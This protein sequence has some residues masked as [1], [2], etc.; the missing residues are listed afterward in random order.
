MQL[1]DIPID[2]LV[3][4]PYN[5]RI[6]LKPGMAE[7]ER[8]KRS[9]TEFELVQPIVWNRRTGY[10]VGGHQRLSILKARGDAIA[11]C[12][13][14]DLDPARE[15]ALNVTLNNERVGGDWEPD[16]LIDVLAD[17]EELPD[18]DATLTGFSADELDELLMIPQTDPPVEEPS[19][20]SDT[21]TAELTIPIERWERIRPEIDRVVATHSLELHVR[22]PNSSEA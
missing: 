20:E 19:T 1:V 18:F 10:V 12:V 15:K 21:V 5:P 7:Y 4:A 16:K 13:I 8:L 3:P 9:L 6:E 17:L 22:M 2:Q 11:P 14:V